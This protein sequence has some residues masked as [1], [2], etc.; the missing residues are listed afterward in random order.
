M[1]EEEVE[2]GTGGGGDGEAAEEVGK[3]VESTAAMGRRWAEEPIA[4]ASVQVESEVGRRGGGGRPV[5][6]TAAW[7]GVG[8]A[9]GAAWWR[10]RVVGEER[11]GEGRRIW[12]RRWCAVAGARAVDLAE[13][14]AARAVD[15]DKGARGGRGHEVAAP[16]VFFASIFFLA[17]IFFWRGKNLGDS[18]FYYF[19]AHL[20]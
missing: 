18:F 11:A 15:G 2:A 4:E 5:E 7:G 16:R 13:E 1:S 14:A 8:E 9:E 6:S 10:R 17:W 3:R 20:N 12:R 19:P